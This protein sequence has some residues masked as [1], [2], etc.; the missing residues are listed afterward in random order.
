MKL[1]IYKYFLKD[2]T[3][4][5]FPIRNISQSIISNVLRCSHVKVIEQPSESHLLI[6]CSWLSHADMGPTDWALNNGKSYQLVGRRRSCSDIN[7]ISHS[8]RSSSALS[9]RFWMNYE[10]ELCKDHSTIVQP[11]ISSSS[12]YLIGFTRMSAEMLSKN[13]F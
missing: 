3:E 2:Q 1:C 4:F 13:I 12:F 6:P 7:L 9:R 11:S 8:N 5:H 10:C